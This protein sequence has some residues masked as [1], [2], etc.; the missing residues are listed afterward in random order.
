MPFSNHNRTDTVEDPHTEFGKTFFGLPEESLDFLF[1]AA[2]HPG[3]RRPRN[4]DHY[5]VIRRSRRSEVLVSNLP[6]LQSANVEDLA[7]G[8]LVADGIGGARFGDLASRLALETVLQAATQATSWIMKFQDLD[9]QQVRQRIAAYVERIQE[10]FQREAEA[11][12]DKQDMG[13]TLTSVYLIPPH[14]LVAQIGDSRAYLWR[15]KQLIQITR[16]Q[17]LAQELIDSGASEAEARR[18]GNILINSLGGGN[19]RAEAAVSHLQLEVRDRLLIC[20]DGLSDLVNAEAI[21]AAMAVP[22]LQ[23][24]CTKLVELALDEGGRDN[25]TVV[26]CEMVS[27]SSLSPTL[28]HDV[29]SDHLT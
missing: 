9:A 12:P 23:S 8:I 22:N 18:F 6:G 11:D 24:V 5:A 17:T 13:T 15:H 27:A 28:P 3:K 2:T 19:R 29:S 4:E 7:W 10:V 21:G 14:A 16:D 20:T 25:I 1:A 26:V